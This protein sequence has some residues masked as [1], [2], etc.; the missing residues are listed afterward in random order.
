VMGDA[1]PNTLSP[2]GNLASVLQAQGK[3]AEAEPLFREATTKAAAHPSLGPNHPQ[4]KR[5]AAKY[6]SCLDA[7]GRREEAAATRNQ[8]GVANATTRPTTQR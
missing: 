5:L 4:T 8:F 2:M 3:L 6:A 1:H 7:M